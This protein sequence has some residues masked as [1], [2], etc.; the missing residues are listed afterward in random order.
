M[1]TYSSGM[2][3]RLAFSVA[4]SMSPDILLVDEALSVGDARFKR[5]SFEK[6]EELCEHA[7]TILIVSHALSSIRRLCERV[8]WLHRGEI[9]MLD[10]ADTVID[11][12]SRF[13]DVGDLDVA[14][15]DV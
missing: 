2:Y 10:D 9:A 13:M 6:M 14:L 7:G 8:L 11:A 4:V 3:G 5:K 1:R 12:Y 15:E